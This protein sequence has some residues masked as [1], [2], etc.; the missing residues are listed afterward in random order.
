MPPIGVLLGGVRFDDL[1]W[2]LRAGETAGP[3]LTLEDAKAAGAAT[4]NYG[5][6]I[7]TIVTFLIVAVAV[8]ML[9]R[10]VNRLRR[11]EQV[12]PAAPTEKPCPYCALVVPL[13]ATRCPHC[14]SSLEAVVA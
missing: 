13:K 2:V 8:F 14:T 3:Y 11:K 6:F 5:V 12:A 4:I 9:V 1:F 10:A 7:N